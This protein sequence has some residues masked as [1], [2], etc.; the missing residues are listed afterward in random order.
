MFDSHSI[1]QYDI[2]LFIF[3]RF[4]NRMRTA[5][6][7][8]HFVSVLISVSDLY[9]HITSQNI[10]LN[11][12]M[13]LKIVIISYLLPN[14]ELSNWL[15]LHWVIWLISE[16]IWIRISIVCLCVC[17]L[18]SIFLCIYLCVVLHMCVQWHFILC[19]SCHGEQTL[20]YE[21]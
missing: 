21:F 9:L 4:T 16:C 6:F 8:S 13:N 7:N 15:V 20:S 1:T 17:K 12:L 3:D 11:H 18:L 10:C 19:L 14:F 5:L 2:A